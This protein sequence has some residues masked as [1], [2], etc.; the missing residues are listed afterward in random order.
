MSNFTLNDKGVWFHPD[1]PLKGEN[2]PAPTWVCSPLKIVAITRDHN[3]EN[4]GRLLEFSDV[5]GIQHIWSM[6]MEL[7][8]ADGAEYRRT[9]LSMGLQING[10]R[11]AKTLL[12]LYIQQN[13]PKQRVRCVTKL[14]WHG[15][16]FVFPDETISIQPQ[17]EPIIFQA[18]SP[19]MTHYKSSGTLQEWQ[20][21]VAYYCMGNTRLIFV[22]S[23]AFAAPLLE[24][25]EEEGGG[26]H[27]YG[28]SSGGKTTATKVAA[29]VHGNPKIHSWRATNNALES[30]ATL[31]ND[32]LL[33]LDELGQL[34]PREAGETAYLLPN[35]M[36]KGRS[37]RKGDARNRYTWRL[38]FLS[39]GELSFPDIIKQG[40]KKVKA[41]QEVRII[42]IPSDTGVYGVFEELHQFRDAKDAS[43]FAR[44]LTDQVERYYG[45][46]GR[47]F[48]KTIAKEPVAAKKRLQMLI[49][50]F[51]EEHRP[52]CADGQV[53]RVLYRFA[54]I[55][56]AGTLAS[57][58][59]ITK[60]P[61][62][63]VFWGVSNCFYS[64]LKNRGGT[65]ALEEKAALRQARY[66]FERY[67]Q[68]RFATFDINPNEKSTIC[69]VSRK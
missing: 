61:P 40:G 57:E 35:G 43:A 32:S 2:T 55:A 3:N 28:N 6:P 8:A 11:E 67:G 51:I 16:T 36:G 20:A 15:P 48:I 29:S 53:I 44:F 19:Q 49:D 62:D 50:K 60:W 63:D 42:D 69:L 46:A 14:G 59:G 37:N 1:P 64:W 31:H 13:V 54:V 24:L 34:D 58:Y 7:L 5:D 12:S 68:S 45:T 26:I 22:V 18:S 10:S 4:H 23:S 33:C 25:L 39:N 65:S 27:I 9:L 66:F 47:E 41:G 52:A 17:S 38:I 21:N 30:I 56:A